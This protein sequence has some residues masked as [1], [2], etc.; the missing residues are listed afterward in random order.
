[1]VAAAKLP[2]LNPN[3][4]DLWKMR[5]EQY[6]LM[7]DYSLW[8]VILNGDSP[9]P[10]R[11]VD[12]VVQIVAPTT[13]EQRLAKKNK[14]KARG[15]LLMA[16][17][18]KHQLKFNIH[19]DANG[20][21]S[22]SFDQI[23]D[24]LQKL[25]SQLEIL[26]ET[27]SQEDI[28]LKF[29]RSLPLEWKTHTLIWKNKAD[30]EEQ[31]LDDL[32]NNLKIYEAEVKDSS[33]SS[34]NIQNIAFVS[35]NNTDSTN[36]S[37]NDAPSV[38]AASL[39]AK[40]STLANVDSL[41][42]D[43]IYSFVISQSNSPQLDNK[44][45]KHID[46]DD[47]EE[48][49]L[50]WQMAMLIMRARR[51]LKKSGRNLVQME[52]IPLGL[53]C[54]KLNVTIGT[55][56]AILP[57]NADHQGTTGTKKLLEELSQWRYLLQMLWC[58]S[59][60][61][62]VVM[63]GVFKL[64]K[65][66]LIM[67]L[68]LTPHQAHQVLHDQIMRKSQLN[69]IS[70][71][72]GLE[73][74]EARLV[75]YQKNETVFEKD[76]KLLKLDV[77]IRDN[78]LAELRKKFE[79]AE[80]EGNDLKLILEK[81]QNSSKNLSKLLE[82]QVSDKTGLGF[83][84]QV[85]N[86]QV[87]D[88]EEFH[89]Q[90]SDNRV[91]E[92]QENDRYKI[93]K[94]YHA[95]PHPYNR[96]F[97]PPKLDL[98]FTDDTNAS[99]SV[100]NVIYVE[101]SEH[102][103]SKDKSKTHRPA[104]PII[105]DWISDS[106]NETKIESVPK[107]REPSFVKSTEHV[108]TSRKSVKKVKHNKQA[109]NLR[110]NNQKSRALELMLP[111]ILKKN[112]KCLMLLPVAPTT[113]EQWLARKNELKA[114]GTL[115]M[116]LPDKHQLKFNSHKDAKTMM[117]AIEKRFGGNTKTKKVQK[118]LLKQQFEN[119][120]GSSSEGLDQIHDSLQKLVSQLEIHGVSLSQED[121]N[122]KFIRSLPSEWKTHTLIWRNNAD[123]EEQSLDDLFNSFKI[124]E[125]EVNQS[126]SPGTA[127]QNLA[128]VSSTHTDSTT[129]SVS[130]AASVSAACVKLPASPLP[131]VD[132]LCNAVIYSFFSS[133]STSHQL[134]NEDLK[135]I[136]TGRNLGA[137]GPTSLG[138]DMSKVEY[139][140]CHKKGHFARE[141]QSPKDSRRPEEEP[142]NFALMAFSSNSSYDNEVP[143]CS[144]AC[145]KA[146]TQLHTQ[147]DKLTDDFCKS[148]F[149]VISYQTCLEYVEARLLVYKQNESVFEENIKLLNIEVQLRDTALVTLKHK[150]E[151]AELERD[152]LK[153][154]LE[155]F[156]TSSKN[157][158]DLLASQTNEKTGLGYNLQVYTKAMFDCE[159]YYSS[160]SD[161]ESWPPS[162]LYDRF[163]PSG[164][165]HAIPPSYTGTFMPPKPYLMFNI[166]STAVETDH[167]A[168][169][170]IK[171]TIPAATP[172]P[173]SPESNS[174]GQRINRKACFVCKSVDHLIKD[175]DYHTKKM[176]QPIKRNYRGHH[177]HYAPLTH[178]KPQKHMV[179]TAVLTQSKPVSN[180]VVR[181]VS[182]ALPNIPVIRPRHAH[183]V[184][185][186]FKSPIRRYIT[187]SP[188][189]RTSHSPP[190]VTAVQ[191][192]VGN[193]QQALKDKG[194]IDS[195]YSRHMTGNMSY[196]SG[197]E[198]LNGGY[199]TFGG[200]PKGGKI[201]GKGKFQG[202][203]DE[204]FLV[205]YSVCSKAFRVFNSRTHFF[206]ET[207]H[208]NFLENKPNVADTGPTWL[209]DI[210]SLTRTMN[211]QPIH[212]DNQTNSGVGFQNNFDAE[213]AG[214]EVDQSYMLFP[215]WSIGSTNPQNN[216][217][218]DAFYGK[219]HDFDVKKPES[220]VI[221]PP[222]SSAQSKEQ[223]DKTMKEAKGKSPVES[224]IRNKDLNT[225]FEDC[226]ENSSNEVNAASF[227]VPTV[228]Q[229]SLNNTNTFS[230]ASPSNDVVSP[231]YGKTS[232]IDASQLPNDPNMPELEDIIYSDDEDVVGVEADF[233]NLESSIPVLVDLPY[234]KRA[235]GTKWVYK[236]KKDE[237][238]IVIR[239]KAR[240]VAQGH[241]Q[242]EGIDYEEVFAP[243]ARIE[244]IRLF[245]AYASFMGF[246]VYQMDVK[247]AFLYGTIKEKV[248]LCQ[249][250][251]FEDPDHPDKV[252]KVVKA[253]YG[254]HQAP[255]AWYET[256]A[257]YLL[258]NGFQKG[259]IDQT[260]FIKNQKGD[261]LLVQIYVDDIIFG[262]TNKDLCRS[263]EKLM[264]NKFQMSSMGEL[265]F[266]LGLQVK[267]KKDGIFIC[268]DKYV[269]EILRKFGLTKGK[270]ASTPID[271]EKPLLKDP[272]VKRIFRYLKGKPHL[273]L[274]YPKDSTFDLVAYSDSDYAG[275]IL[276]IKS[277]T[278]GCRFLGCRLI[279]WQCK[280]QTVVATS[281]IEAEYVAAVEG[282]KREFSVP[283]TPQQNS[284]A[285]RKNRTLI[286]AARTMLADSLLP[287]PFWAEAVNTACYVQNRVLVTK[288]HNK[289]PY[290]LFHGR[291]PSI[292]F[293]RPFGC[294]VTILNTLD[295][296]GKFQGK[297]DER[298]LVGYSE[299]D[300]DVKKPES[301]VILSPSSSAQ[302]NKQD[303][304]T[305][306]EAKGKS[307]IESVTGYRD[308]NA[309]F[310][311]CSENS[312][313]EV[314]AAGSVV[315]TV[316]QNSLYITNTFSA[317]GPSNDVVSPSYGKYSFI[318]ASQLPDDLD[319]PK[320]EDIT[321]SDDDE[322]SKRV[323]QAFKDP[324]WIEAM[325]EELLQFKMQKVWVLVD[326]PYRKRA[327]DD[328]IFGAT[329]KD[330][331]RSFEKLMKD[332][333]QMSSMGEL[334]F[335]LGLQV[336]QKKDGIF[337][338]QDKYVAKILRKF[339]LTEG[340]SASTPI[341]TEKPLLKDPDG[342]D[343]DVHTYRS[344]IGS[345]MYLT[346][347]RP[348]IMFAVCAYVQ[349]TLKALHL[350][351]VKRIFRYLKGKPH[352]G[353]WYPKNSPFD[354]VAYSDS[355]YAGASLDRKSTTG[356]CQFLGCRLISW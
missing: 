157:L 206:Q 174:S 40:V 324:S 348:D 303:D 356:G 109:E 14:L 123:L 176:A 249:P 59:G 9:P 49:D 170:K 347:S 142:A 353:L 275:A 198:E 134:D 94:G 80:K 234:G 77:I 192:P 180:T 88:C 337:I 216:A 110:I 302:S 266:F 39:K 68:W 267:K 31:S 201:T 26:G 128:F 341:D 218:D 252:Y 276:D 117:E 281:S 334:T 335:F 64:K 164:G 256:L 179:P 352:L 171:T 133:Q 83:D 73:S 146:Y 16:L 321:Y 19:K 265:T 186:K 269:A 63:I 325:Q 261:I 197:F 238:G 4:F 339:G 41:S 169:N 103:T 181:P 355:D 295:P 15:T 101:S 202:K 91:T 263:F 308:L 113:A 310:E 8:E 228:G 349:V 62:L 66:L 243:V 254:L 10:T 3:K 84:S 52:Q 268:Q 25:I 317:A 106:E 105:K 342:E 86:C 43:V 167:L 46:P 221:I 136:D 108:K 100:A 159:N 107:Q 239:N 351:A 24:R 121:V 78:A 350:H 85:F 188:Y 260:L 208:V 21:S 120:T 209:F 42:D 322:E 144:K 2:I 258:E 55:E 132:S 93:G 28:N 293:M 75:V 225:E 27:I 323:H 111:W 151:K 137:N 81:F 32:F 166:A 232:D 329:N 185:T 148:Q 104:T 190:R 97:L 312:S 145:S 153:L 296:L 156:Q 227:T 236:N 214:E 204:G 76:I 67:H 191:A 330:L 196:L 230:A 13:A 35:L 271:T 61:Q 346:S 212:A 219:E 45:L 147:Y 237:R 304:K 119:F 162:N 20:T 305:K 48:M 264:K 194:I 57:G 60:M 56:E 143:S 5:I 247:S 89:S 288:P 12:D 118:T 344:M 92:N 327:I 309:E 114:H 354:L 248:Y 70:Y 270:S 155:K 37:V 36:E 299:H 279:S 122:L 273:G 274:W 300:F 311:D 301:E 316:G 99:E 149:D 226:S 34:Q 200:N 222:S 207:L 154:K 280:K 182:A 124:Y 229:N 152:D 187:R 82:S 213:K 172:V 326:L 297:V 139:Y 23:H 7:T 168:F 131:N 184:V 95:V 294:L 289:T 245:L 178:S 163:Q 38:S 262:A 231:T 102:K 287:I 116:A 203:V 29:L 53:I 127:S 242:E 331:C 138:F 272:D 54:P 319:M 129:D 333:F 96:N 90:E 215:V 158:T 223:D 306:K 336:K 220:K 22:E 1:M 283:R 255:R 58:L 17:P 130:A 18:D 307:P 320:L 257:T 340:K 140:N 79:K 251:G 87:S 244:A 11:I 298:F 47:L 345:L 224:V 246:M 161:Y 69:V 343:V 240:L 285:E 30:L 291:T 74:V 241:T 210:A 328:I 173:A 332:K 50:K 338:S 175:C 33:T 205:G 126:S 98:V 51:F 65:N 259:T 277:T 165:Y 282:I 233:N 278:G 112:T 150:L 183:Q 286:E 292:G 195:G 313:N 44:D 125:T 235:I 284:I 290:E 217:E 211:Y 141:C 199:V 250:P 189:S 135:Q 318:D 193:L 253:L 177:K 72:T 6:F 115:L 160:E 314:N 315:P 71:K